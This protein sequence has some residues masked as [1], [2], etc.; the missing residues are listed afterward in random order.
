MVHTLQLHRQTLQWNLRQKLFGIKWAKNNAG[1][2]IS[3]MSEQHKNSPTKAIWN[4][5]L[6][7]KL[8]PTS[9]NHQIAKIH[10][11]FTPL[12]SVGRRLS[13]LDFGVVVSPPPAVCENKVI[14][15][16]PD[17]PSDV[18]SQSVNGKVSQNRGGWWQIRAVIYLVSGAADWWEELSVMGTS[19]F[20][21]WWARW[22]MGSVRVSVPVA[23][24]VGKVLEVWNRHPDTA[25]TSEHTE[26]TNV[27]AGSKSI[28]FLM[29]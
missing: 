25:A 21:L 23:F 29:I 15:A 27:Y 3:A 2:L 7:S 8:H 22:E 17:A 24:N 6:H 16:D 5:V 13:R 20:L 28:L 26:S 12:S 4:Q 14:T 18:F 19:L 10:C 11:V 1:G 9:R